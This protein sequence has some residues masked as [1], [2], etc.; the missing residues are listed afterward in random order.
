MESIVYEGNLVAIVF[1]DRV[2]LLPDVEFGD[3]RVARFVVAMAAY[4]LNPERVAE[5]E[6]IEEGECEFI[7]RWLLMPNAAFAPL[8]HLP[9]D[10]L[11]EIFEV[12]MAEVARKREDLARVAAL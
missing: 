8:A 5:G 1:G 2:R 6:A 10:R 4:M 7:A 9:D 3:R 12:P 11:A